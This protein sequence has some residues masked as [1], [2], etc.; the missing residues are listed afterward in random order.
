[1]LH[2]FFALSILSAS[3]GEPPPPGKQTRFEP[4]ESGFSVIFPGEPKQKSASQPTP[5]VNHEI[6]SY[7]YKVS[8]QLALLVTYEELSA[9]AVK[10]TSKTLQQSVRG[11]ALLQKGVV[12]KESDTKQN[13]NPAKDYEIDC[14]TLIYK[15]RYVLVGKRLYNTAAF[16]SKKSGATRQEEVKGFID[17]FQILK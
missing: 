14:G 9:A 7:T 1:M 16:V 13:D 4:P 12:T 11:A 17:S 3:S 5:W 6:H 15:G 2:L 10:D 8:P